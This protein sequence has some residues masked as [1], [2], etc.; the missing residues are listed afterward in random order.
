MAT[1]HVR[2]LPCLVAFQEDQS[3]ENLKLSQGNFSLTLQG[4]KLE[5]NMEQ[6]LLTC[7][8]SDFFLCLMLSCVVLCVQAPRVVEAKGPTAV[9]KACAERREDLV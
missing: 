2:H 4:W 9:S 1:G 7:K 6:Q 8:H 5:I 3:W